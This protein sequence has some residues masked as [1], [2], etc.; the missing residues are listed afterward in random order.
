MRLHSLPMPR[1]PFLRFGLPML[2]LL[3]IAVWPLVSGGRTLFLRDVFGTHLEMKW[4]QARAMEEGYL[5][6]VDARRGGGQPHLGNPNTVPLYPDNLLYLVAPFF[7]AFNAHF[8]L[9][10]LLA[11][12]LFYLLARAWGLDPPAAW[13]AAALWGAGGFLLSQMNL[14]N[15][16]A[17]VALTPALIAAALRSA[18]GE[19]RRA[20]PWLATVLVWALLLLGGDPIVA[21]LALAMAVSAIAVRGERRLS[22]WGWWLAGVAVGTLL[23]APQLVEFGR[24]VSQSFRGYWGYSSAGSLVASWH[25]AQVA[26]WLVPFPFGLPSLRFWGWELFGGNPPLFFTLTPGVLTVALFVL[27][28]RGRGERV[29]WWS[30]GAIAAGVFFALGT[31]NPL[32]RLLVRLPVAEALRFPVKLWLPVAIGAALI[33]GV[34]FARLVAGRRRPMLWS[35]AVLAALYLALWLPLSLAPQWSESMLA[36]WMPASE[37]GYLPGPERVRL[38]GHCL[39]GLVLVAAYAVLVA[40]LGRRAGWAAAGLVALHVASQLFLLRPVLASDEAAYYRQPPSLLERVPAEARLVSGGQNRLFGSESYDLRDLPDFS[41]RWVAR[42]N[43]QSLYPWA[44]ALRGRRYELNVSP[45]G[46]DGFLTVAAAQA[47]KSADDA[48]RLRL[49]RVFGVGYLCLSRPL[50]DAA[51]S[52]AVLVATEET[53]GQTAYLYRLRQPV[54]AVRFVGTVHRSEHLNAALD[55]LLDPAFDPARQT[56]LAGDGPGLQGPPGRVAV[57]SRSEEE[58]RIDVAAPGPGVLVLQRSYLPIYRATVDDRPVPVRVADLHR[59]AVRIEEPGRHRVRIW[60]D[61]R[62]WRWGLAGSGVGL[63]LLAVGVVGLR[64]PAGRPSVSSRPEA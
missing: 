30:W 61:R 37:A 59:L 35:L 18:E 5:P 44:G 40:R 38:A 3:T 45:E 4:V 21:A 51:A 46:L 57:R 53:L 63:V 10:L 33:G 14:Y 11:P 6:V 39:L 15:L 8:W 36:A 24:I 23:A 12:W 58:W 43:Y 2:A 60:V 52:E 34:G 29:V 64:N 7:W 16:V 50:G 25:P 48:V 49:L 17:P 26:E 22:V 19:G 47:V 27:G 42:Q 62:P 41:L 55:V 9:H 32:V 1:R 28:A 13:A 54:P 56:V 20:L 31:H